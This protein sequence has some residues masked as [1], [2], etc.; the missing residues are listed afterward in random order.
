MSVT[1]KPDLRSRLA[2]LPG[3]TSKGARVD[4]DVTPQGGNRPRVVIERSGNRNFPHL[5]GQDDS[6]IFEEFRI[7]SYATTSK[8]AEEVSDAIA[9]DLEAMTG[10]LGSTRAVKGVEIIDKDDDFLSGAERTGEASVNI[11]CEIQHVPQ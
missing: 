3:V 4:V 10:N 8:V 2:A 7:T 9:D 6:L 1:I 11:T 5:G